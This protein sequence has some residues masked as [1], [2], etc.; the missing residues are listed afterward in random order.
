MMLQWLKKK[1]SQWD[2]I[3]LFHAA[4]NENLNNMKWLKEINCLWNQVT[5][6]VAAEKGILGNME[7][8]KKNLAMNML[9]I[10]QL[11]KGISTT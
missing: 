3:T 11:G 4:G 7:W 10:V 6:T 1:N 5:F 9:F 8:L 2:E